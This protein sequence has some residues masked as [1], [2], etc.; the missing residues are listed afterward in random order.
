MRE[1]S[2]VFIGV[3]I[4]LST[5]LLILYGMLALSPLQPKRD[6]A[7]NTNV[8]LT[9][10]DKPKIDYANPARG[11]A[12]PLVTIVE[13]GDYLCA[14][15][16]QLESELNALLKDEG[17]KVRV[18]WKDFPN[19]NLHAGAHDAAS[20]ARCAGFQGGFWSFHD[21]LMANQGSISTD[22][23]PILAKQAG[24]DGAAIS[25]CLDA[26]DGDPLVDRDLEE[27]LRL[28]IDGT[29]YLFIGDRR[30][31]GA[32]DDQQLRALVDSAI[33]QAEHAPPAD[34]NAAA[35]TNAATP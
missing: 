24:L 13:F 7:A 20:A 17:D 14:P 8:S 28:R 1:Q 12:Q 31:S 26:K 25:A 4:L 5:A 29:P 11:A 27:G 18:V 3:T 32:I 6:G 16:A 23:F 34:A 35:P 30:I 9:P 15:C 2:N 33:A 10:L 21:V 19:S 22:N